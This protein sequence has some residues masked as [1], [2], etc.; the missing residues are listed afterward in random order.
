MAWPNKALQPTVNRCA[1]C[2]RLS[3]GVD[4][5]SAV[6]RGTFGVS[7]MACAVGV[8]E[9]PADGAASTSDGRSS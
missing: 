4:M 8:F 1:V 3:L 2:R 5:T 6:K 9:S 7:D